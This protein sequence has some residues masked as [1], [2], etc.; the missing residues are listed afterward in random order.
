MELWTLLPSAGHHPV[1]LCFLRAVRECSSGLAP[2]PK[3]SCA[4]ESPRVRKSIA[5]LHSLPSL[6]CWDSDSVGL[7]WDLGVCI[8]QWA[9][10]HVFCSYSISG[11]RFTPEKHWSWPSE[12]SPLRSRGPNPSPCRRKLRLFSHGTQLANR[13][14]RNPCFSHTWIHITICLVSFI[15]YFSI[16]LRI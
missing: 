12:L 13:I 7:G 4:S 1:L 8:F 3:L 5:S 9:H 16:Y 10:K 2:G 6:L 15:T 11:S 14:W